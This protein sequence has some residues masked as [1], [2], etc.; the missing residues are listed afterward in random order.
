[1]AVDWQNE[2][3]VN[4]WKWDGFVDRAQ[5][6]AFPAA[7]GVPG[8]ANRHMTG[9]YQ[10]MYHVTDMWE[11]WIYMFELVRENGQDINKLWISLHAM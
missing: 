8:Y 4:Y 1:M 10:H 11:V 6:N 2:Y 9:G 7:D 5:Y 3:G